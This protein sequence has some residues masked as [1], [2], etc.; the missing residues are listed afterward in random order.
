VIAIKHRQV[1]W[2]RLRNWRSILLSTDMMFVRS[3]VTLEN[4]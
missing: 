3:T 4:C 1:S 2:N